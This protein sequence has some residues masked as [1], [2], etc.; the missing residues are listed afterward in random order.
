MLSFSGLPVDS[1]RMTS[2]ESQLRATGLKFR[3]DLQDVMLC[4]LSNV[5][6]FRSVSE[7]LSAIEVCTFSNVLYWVSQKMYLT[8]T[9]YFEAVAAI[10]SGILNFPVSSDLYNSIDTLLICFHDL[11]NK[12]HYVIFQA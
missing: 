5:K 11:M 8:L 9:L 1:L 12:W 3:Y 6:A 4:F 2:S 10:M 7:E